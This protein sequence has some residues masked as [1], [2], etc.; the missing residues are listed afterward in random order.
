MEA[1][2][3]A[4]RRATQI[5]M[6]YVRPAAGQAAQPGSADSKSHG[7]DHA[8]ESAM[9]ADPTPAQPMRAATPLG[10]LSAGLP[11]DETELDI[12]T[13]LRQP[14]ELRRPRE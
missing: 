14:L 13:F 2:P 10:H 4:P 1:A 11:S 7:R 3:V 12:P 6:P 9:R 8:R 5:T